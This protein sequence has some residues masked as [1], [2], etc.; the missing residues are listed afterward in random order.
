M[1]NQT[2][3]EV[4]RKLLRS[5]KEFVNTYPP[6]AVIPSPLYKRDLLSQ[7]VRGSGRDQD[8]VILAP[9]IIKKTA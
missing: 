5:C 7:G 9:T 2:K 6:A 4:V 3:K 1:I 8:L